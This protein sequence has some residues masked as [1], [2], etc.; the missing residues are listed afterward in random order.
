MLLRWVSGLSISLLLAWGVTA[1]STENLVPQVWQPKLKRNLPAEGWALDARREAWA[2]TRFGD[3]SLAGVPNVNAIN[4]PKVLIWGDSFVEAAEVP[5]HKKIH[6]VLTTLLEEDGGPLL[7]G[8]A[9]GHRWWCL[10]DVFFGI[11]AYESAI[12]NPKLHVIH[13]FGLQDTLPDREPSVRISQFLSE[14]NFHFEYYDNEY[15]EAE[16][17]E[18]P[19]GL[20][21]RTVY[22]ARVQFFLR[23]LRSAKEVATLD[24]LRFS[25]GSQAPQIES[26]PEEARL[27][28]WSEHL[29]PDWVKQDPPIEAWRFLLASLKDITDVPIVFVYAT[30]TPGLYHGQVIDRNP[31]Q[32][33]V[34]VFASLCKEF[35]FGFS[36]AEAAITDHWETTGRFHRGFPT[37]RPGE[38]HYNADG[39]R[40]LA[41]TIRAW[42]RANAH[43]VHPD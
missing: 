24:G 3:L 21:R 32:E 19:P 39:N 1:V 7:A 23:L 27:H 35:G 26:A 12:D 31:E 9:I 4:S 25:L 30:P 10:A 16:P 42:I 40:I 17:P 2:R 13:L 36:S 28:G 34:P 18:Q 43:V 33:W 20:L 5:D 41:E 37:S 11:P 15:G 6:N 22:R 29:D 14:P 8:V 38:G